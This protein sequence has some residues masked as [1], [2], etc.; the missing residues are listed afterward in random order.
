MVGVAA[1]IPSVL[2]LVLAVILVVVCVTQWKNYSLNQVTTLHLLGALLLPSLD[3]HIRNLIQHP[4]QLSASSGPHP[5]AFR[6]P[7]LY[8]SKAGPQPRS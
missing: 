8:L 4:L 1:G 5:L 7:L 6:L 2:T 3:L